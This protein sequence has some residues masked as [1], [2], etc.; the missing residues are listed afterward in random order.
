MKTFHLYILSNVSRMLYVGVTGDLQRRMFE[1][2][3]K[4]LPGYSR[5]YNLHTLVYTEAFG[6]INDAISREKQIKSW[7]RSK[8]TALIK[9]TNP[10]WN[11]LAQDLA[12]GH[13]TTARPA[14][15]CH[16]SATR[17]G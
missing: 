2:K 3:K 14:K 4:L 17:R 15:T 10:Q 12:P 16:P 9:S 11:D 13:F 7:P 5:N 6:N 8:K 1:H